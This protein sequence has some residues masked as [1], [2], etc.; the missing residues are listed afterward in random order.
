MTKLISKTKNEAYYDVLNGDLS[1]YFDEDGNYDGADYIKC[2]EW[3]TFNKEEIDDVR[4][5]LEKYGIDL[6]I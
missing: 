2:G 4:Y 1:I 6:E 5:L 3:M